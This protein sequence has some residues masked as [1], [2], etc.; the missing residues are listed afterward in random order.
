M[1]LTKIIILLM[2]LNI[3]TN[4]DAFSLEERVNFRKETLENGLRVIYHIDRSAPVVSTILHYEVGSKD[5]D[6]GKT[7]YAHFFE[8]LMF[9]AAGSIGRAEIPKLINESGGWLNAH[10]SFDET[11]YKF[12]VSSNEVQL[13]LWIEAQRMR[14][15]NVEEV[16]VETQRGVV[17]EEKKQRVDNQPYGTMLEK[18]LAGLFL[19]GTYSWATIGKEIDIQNAKIEDF[20]NFYDRFYQPNNAILVVSGNFIIQDVREYIINYFGSIPLADTIIRNP[21]KID[22][23]RKEHRENVIDDKA[24]HKAVFIGFK[25]PNIGSEDYYA[26][27]LL[28]N[29][30]A[31]GESSRLYKRLVNKDEI[32]MQTSMF[33]F[34]LQEDGAIIFYGVAFPNKNLSDIEKA[35]YDEISKIIKEGISDEELQKV[36]NI[37]EMELLQ[38][39]RN[40]MQKAMQL[41]RFEAYYK[42]PE[43][44]NNQLANFNAVTKQDIQKV[45]EKYLSTKNRVVLNYLPKEK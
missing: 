43:L 11:V 6:F 18:M 31:S 33:P 37:N 8:H 28:S 30:L 36:K 42:N 25:G 1:R 26:I 45:A 21:V 35:I 20:Q 7:G 2:A 29:I 23:L 41:A 10:T 14:L 15:L 32:A 17:L 12:K 38:S 13:P 3:M 22:T 19:T 9:E 24:P 34:N 27:N 44:I 4:E 5:E 39:Q 40:V 16:G